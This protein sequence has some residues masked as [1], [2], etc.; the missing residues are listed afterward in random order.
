MQYQDA[1]KERIGDDSM[2]LP[3]L[4][5]FDSQKQPELTREMIRAGLTKICEG[6]LENYDPSTD[7]SNITAVLEQTGGM[8]AHKYIERLD[9]AYA[10]RRM[11]ME[12]EPDNKEH[13]IP[14]PFVEL[15]GV[16]NDFFSNEDLCNNETMITGE[17]VCKVFD[18]CLFISELIE[19]QRTQAVA[20]SAKFGKICKSQK[21]KVRSRD[22]EIARLNRQMM[23]TNSEAFNLDV[24]QDQNA[25]LINQNKNLQ[26]QLDEMRQQISN[27]QEENEQKSKEHKE[28]SID[29]KIAKSHAE[30]MDKGAALTISDKN[31][32]EDE[33][34]QSMKAKQLV[35]QKN[36]EQEEE[37]Q[38]HLEELEIKAAR[39][40]Q[41]ESQMANLE[42][43]KEL[44]KKELMKEVK[45]S[46]AEEKQ[47]LLGL[48]NKQANVT[49]QDQDR[50]A[51]LGSRSTV[52]AADCVRRISHDNPLVDD[53]DM[54]VNAK[55]AN[56]DDGD[57]S[58]M[59]KLKLQ[60]LST[61]KKI[62]NDFG[63]RN[64]LKAKADQMVKRHSENPDSD[65]A[66]GSLSS[67]A[68]GPEAFFG[69][70]APII[71]SDSDKESDTEVKRVDITSAADG[72]SAISRSNRG[73]MKSKGSGSLRNKLSGKLQ[74]RIRRQ[75][76]KAMKQM[77]VEESKDED[78]E[79]MMTVL[80]EKLN[81]VDEDNPSDG[82]EADYDVIGLSSKDSD[83]HEP[84]VKTL[85]QFKD[86]FN[87][88]EIKFEVEAAA[89]SP[90]MLGVDCEVY[91]AQKRQHAILCITE[92][93][94]LLVF[95]GTKSAVINPISIN[96]VQ[97]LYLAEN[98][99][100]AA[101]LHLTAEIEEL[102]GQS[103]LII[104]SPSMG[105]I[106][107]YVIEKNYRTEIDFCDELEIK[108]ASAPS[109]FFFSDL[110][111]MRKNEMDQWSNGTVR[112]VHVEEKLFELEENTFSADVWHKRCGVITNLGIFLFDEKNWKKRPDFHS[113]DQFTYQLK[114]KRAVHDGMPNLFLF[115][116]GDA[117]MKTYSIKIKDDM[118]QFVLTLKRMLKE[119]TTAKKDGYLDPTPPY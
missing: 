76:T 53:H 78:N 33:L 89:T 7:P 5:L 106:M 55:K 69:K 91:S 105:L 66:V 72:R 22:E 12:A 35:E 70:S 92:G 37:L 95:K 32:V 74:E 83:Y 60:R 10:E 21:E 114:D 81:E 110:P 39:V 44:M 88:E 115:K 99:P 31:K 68:Y 104:E 42:L 75:T 112:S 50:F 97:T 23:E 96:S 26:Q 40:D 85:Q 118:T 16:L 45:M 18:I 2:S 15:Q 98:V 36:K 86:R 46:M 65:S 57:L 13:Q 64:G 80:D 63:A 111:I 29:L 116:S 4:N 119:Y 51:M 38:K 67:V 109:D 49:K 73:S 56:D 108:I 113:W 17:D 9:I 59:M 77:I 87:T 25:Q 11:K 6:Q 103:H 20:I 27:L 8:Y 101:A 102:V 61:F 41:L 90:K 79:D 82:G 24:L 3:L 43:D 48:R 54:R 47:K 52:M 94:L 14:E 19:I 107:R 93:I 100:S 1:I 28:M 30:T 62:D 34:R 58:K 117:Y 71:D 84:I